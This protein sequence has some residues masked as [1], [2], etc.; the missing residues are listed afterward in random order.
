MRLRSIVAIR[1][2][3]FA[4]SKTAS[5]SESEDLEEAYFKN[6]ESAMD[7][8]CIFFCDTKLIIEILSSFLNWTFLLDFLTNG[9]SPP[10]EATMS[11][12]RDFDLAL[13]LG[14][15]FR[16]TEEGVECLFL[17]RL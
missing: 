14:F 16:E 8:D 3:S 5:L 9:E 7:L 4:D 6:E 2:L 12:V 10:S 13:A 1:S 15:F 11:L 17:S